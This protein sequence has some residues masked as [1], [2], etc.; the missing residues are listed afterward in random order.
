MSGLGERVWD[1]LTARGFTVFALTAALLA[2][3]TAWVCP[4]IF[5]SDSVLFLSAALAGLA[6]GWA[7]GRLPLPPWAAGAAASSLGMDFLFFTIARL[8]IPL[9]SWIGRSFAALLNLLPQ[10]RDPQ[11]TPGPWLADAQ[12]LLLGPVT[13]VLRLL[14]WV[15]TMRSGGEFFD[16][17]ASALLWGAIFCLT[18][19]FAG[20]A[21]SARSRPLAGILPAVLLMAAVFAVAGGDWRPVVVA[22]GLALVFTAAVEHGQ[23]ELEWERKRLGY[24]TALRWDLLFS[25]APVIIALTAG[26]YLLPSVSL[27]EI[28]RWIREHTRQESAPS[29]AVAGDF[30]SGPASGG[31]QGTSDVKVVPRSHFLGAGPDLSDQ[32]VLVIVTGES[33]RYLPGIREPVAPRHYWKAMT[34]DL[35]SGSG[36]LTS[37]TE[38]R[39]LPP[40]S[41]IHETA[42][43]GILLHQEVSVRRP[44]MG[45]VFAAGEL[46]KVYQVVRVV[47]RSNEDLLGVLV[48]ETDYQADSAYLLADEDALRAAGSNY[49][50]WILD[51]YLQLPAILPRRVHA[52]ARDLTATLPTPYDRALAIESYLRREMTYSLDVGEPPYAQ[53]VV[54]Y[55]LFDSKQGFC[56]YYA[57]AMVVLA[58]SAGIPARLAMGY[59]SGIFDPEQGSFTVLESDSHAWPELY[60]PGIGWVEFEPTSS[61]PTVPR[62]TP[63]SAPPSGAEPPRPVDPRLD[64]VLGTAAAVLQRIAVPGLILLAALPLL[65][66]LWILL[67]PLRL[68]LLPPARAVRAVYRG[69]VAHGRRQGIPFSKATTPEEFAGRL[70]V[71]HPADESALRRAAELYGRLA[72]GGRPIT[73]RQK[74]EAVDAW[75]RLDIRMWR[76]WWKSRLAFLRRGK[77]RGAAN[78]SAV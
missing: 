62:S 66:W 58:R 55:F 16:A 2:A 23:K 67:A 42:P 41:A 14:N 71:R 52:L 38:D 75:R 37:P 7:M 44:G 46:I 50:Q 63:P 47:L 45:P 18:G 69:L 48:P 26:S 56:D 17:V 13:I 20:W 70:A 72:Y 35:Y 65:L 77:K 29:G 36:W 73:R 53:D 24:T 49:P 57:S 43:Q 10:F 21:I 6:A 51:R 27:D 8:D 74:R 30:G 4:H 31:A 28:T 39:N 68:L 33:L 34:Y 12:R 9:R 5:R 25:T 1:W 19:A 76:A 78:P 64:A 40:E 32:V 11:F 61:M 54:D 59:G 22:A 3:V 15:Q 60:F